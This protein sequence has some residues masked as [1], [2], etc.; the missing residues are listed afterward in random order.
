MNREELNYIKELKQGRSAYEYHDQSAGTIRL[1]IIYR[2]ER[3]FFQINDRAL[4]CD[5][6]ARDSMLG[7]RSLK[8]WD[9]G[10]LIGAEDRELLVALIQKYYTLSYRDVLVVV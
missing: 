10:R 6:S 8:K 7:K 3:L 4:I 5:I 2:G 1:L 9:D